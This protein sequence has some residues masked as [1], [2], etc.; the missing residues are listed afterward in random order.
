MRLTPDDT[1]D[2]CLGTTTREENLSLG[3]IVPEFGVSDTSH[4]HGEEPVPRDCVVV[5]YVL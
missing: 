4:D 1:P 2:P 3:T 5:E